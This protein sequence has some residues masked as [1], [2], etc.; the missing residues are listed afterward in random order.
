MH[1]RG[2]FGESIK[3]WTPGVKDPLDETLNLGVGRVQRPGLC[4]WGRLTPFYSDLPSQP[5]KTH[6]NPLLLGL[7]AM[8]NPRGVPLPLPNKGE[9][10]GWMRGVLGEAQGYNPGVVEPQKP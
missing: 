7:A 1:C 2:M 3:G 5:H 6:P 10:G 9:L 4:P 8:P